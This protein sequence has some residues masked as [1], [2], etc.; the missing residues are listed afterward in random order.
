[1]TFDT[2]KTGGGEFFKPDNHKNDYAILIEVKRDAPNSP[3]YQGKLTDAVYAD[4]TCFATEADLAEGASPRVYRNAR[5]D[6]ALLQRELRDNVGVGNETIRVLGRWAGR[7]GN[8]MWVWKYT[9]TDTRRAVIE[10]YER[11]EAARAGIDDEFEA[12]LG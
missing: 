3:G 2:P 5:I 12:L 7:T 11:R 8:E 1:M 10:W 6:R 4:L 9:D